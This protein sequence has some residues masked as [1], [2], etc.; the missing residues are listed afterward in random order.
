MSQPPPPPPPS[1]PLPAAPSCSSAAMAETQKLPVFSPPALLDYPHRR[2]PPLDQLKPLDIPPPPTAVPPR[3]DHHHLSSRSPIPITTTTHLPS[4]HAGLNPRQQQQQGQQQRQHH[5]HHHD[6]PPSATAAPRPA[7]PVDK[8]LHTSCNSP[9]SSPQHYGPPLSPPRSEYDARVPRSLAEQQRYAYDEPRHA[10]HH[11][12]HHQQQ[13]APAPTHFHPHAHTDAHAHA[14]AQAPAHSHAFPHPHHDPSPYPSS[15]ASPVEHAPQ[16]RTYAAYTPS[17]P[18]T[19]P[20]RASVGSLQHAQRGSI[21]APFASAAYP[22]APPLQNPPSRAIPLPGSIPQPVY[23]EQLYA[24]L[25]SRE[26]HPADKT[27][28]TST[29]SSGYGSNP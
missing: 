4:I 28:A 10:H 11:H 8:L 9:Y 20:F 24:P 25:A 7:A 29:T 26:E 17:Y 23:N 21:A 14:H 18:S 19:S 2:L 15:L 1:P 16:H 12:H 27:T 13:H 6:Y 5:H 22:D 3:S